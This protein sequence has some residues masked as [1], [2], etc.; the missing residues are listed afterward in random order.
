MNDFLKNNSPWSQLVNLKNI[1]LKILKAGSVIKLTDEIS[2]TPVL[3]PHRD[4][5]SETVG[6]SI[7]TEKK[8]VLFIPDIDK[9]QKWD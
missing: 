8:S 6:F 4:E 7:K 1:Q 5:F 3:V 9:W 2:V